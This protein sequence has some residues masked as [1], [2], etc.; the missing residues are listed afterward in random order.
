MPS[1]V[2]ASGRGRKGKE[3]QSVLGVDLGKVIPCV[4]YATSSAYMT[5]T[6]K[7]VVMSLK[8]VKSIFL[9]YQNFAALF[10][11]FPAYFGWLKRF[12]I[13]RYD[14]WDTKV[15]LR[16][17][18]LGITYTVMLYSSNYAL[19]LLTVPMVSVLKNLGPILITVTEAYMDEKTL[20]RY[21]LISM[22]MLVLGSLVAGFN[23]LKYDT[24]GYLSM[25]FNVSTNLL[26]VQLTKYIQKSGG[27]KKEVVLHYQSVFMCILLLPLLAGQN[28]PLILSKLMMQD[29]D[30]LVAFLS[31]G[32]NGIV[33]ALCSMWCIEKTSGSTYSMVGALNK[34]PSS[35]LGLIIFNDPIDVLNLLGVAI[36]LLGG[37]VFT[38][39]GGR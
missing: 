7:Y 15:A 20:S 33:I 31:T 17:L 22:V 30:V 1:V 28:I 6:Q 11:F 5:L 23:D 10:L 29:L 14:F 9:F 26:H 27:I 36:G 16:V 19:S 32:I 18:P 37:I 39:G 21:T 12:N 34:I 38:F 2:K 3:E 4:C 35:I 8:E 13:T 24:I 25:F